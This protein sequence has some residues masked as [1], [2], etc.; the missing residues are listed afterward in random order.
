MDS[1]NDWPTMEAVHFFVTKYDNIEKMLEH[2]RLLMKI[3]VNDLKQIKQ[4]RFVVLVITETLLLNLQFRDE[5]FVKSMVH[6]SVQK[7]HSAK[8]LTE[9]TEHFRRKLEHGY[10]QIAKLRCKREYIKFLF[11]K[12]EFGPHIAGIIASF[13]E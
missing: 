10:L 6:T 2:F 3:A 5:P 4:Q 9:Y 1:G 11:S 7:L 8:H 12:S 13:V